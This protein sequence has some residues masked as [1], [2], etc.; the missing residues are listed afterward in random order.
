MA[1]QD[2][3]DGVSSWTTGVRMRSKLAFCLAPLLASA[4]AGPASSQEPVLDRL[5]MIHVAVSDMDKSKAFYTD[6]LGF[7]AT[8]DYGHGGQRWVSLVLPG[9]GASINLTTFPENMKPG[10]M[11][12]YFSTPDVEA[13]YKKLKAKGVKPTHEISDDSWGRWFSVADPDGDQ[14]IVVQS[15]RR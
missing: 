6:K 10:T 3:R 11:K 4:L 2:I 14:V 8:Q 15:P 9:G 1:R 7:N 13:A 12:L 5:L